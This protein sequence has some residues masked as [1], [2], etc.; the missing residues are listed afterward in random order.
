MFESVDAVDGDDGNL[1]TV[2]ADEFRV[3]VDVDLCERELIRATSGG[4]CPFS[5]FAEMAAGAC[6]DDDLGLNR[7][8]WRAKSLR[9]RRSRLIDVGSGAENSSCNGN[10]KRV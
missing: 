5:L 10:V 2:A 3:G 6:V 4:D 9:E 1:P 8:V 7:H